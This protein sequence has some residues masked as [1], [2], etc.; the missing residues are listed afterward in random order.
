M[1]VIDV[2]ELL[3]KISPARVLRDVLS[4]IAVQQFIIDLN[5]EG[6]LLKGVNSL[7]VKLST[8]GGNY[9]VTTQLIKGVVDP[10]KVNLYDTGDYYNSYAIIPQTNGDFIIKSDPIKDGISLEDRWG[11]DLEGLTDENLEKLN[12][13]LEGKIIEHLESLL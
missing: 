13:Y 1:D 11:S 8:I 7:G 12:K 3:E 4:N 5:T 6:Q 9:S 2:A 10:S